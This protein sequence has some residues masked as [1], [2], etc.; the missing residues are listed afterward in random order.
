MLHWHV[1][2]DVREEREEAHDH[3]EDLEQESHSIHRDSKL[4]QRPPRG[5]QWLAEE[6]TPKDAADGERIGRCN[7][8]GD[9]AADTVEDFALPIVRTQIMERK[10]GNLHTPPRLMRDNTNATTR[11][12]IMA[13]SGKWVPRTTVTFINHP[14]NG[15][16]RMKNPDVSEQLDVCM[17]GLVLPSSRANAQACRDAAATELRHMLYAKM[18]K[19]MVMPIP[20]ALLP[21]AAAH[22]MISLSSTVKSNATVLT[23][24]DTHEREGLL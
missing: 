24:K 17:L 2:C 16:P 23:N 6:P 12:A 15:S 7:G 13:L 19:G 4:P 18:M 10:I 9:N 21:V 5:R 3:D 20:P 14:G 8:A 22:N 1:R 11:V